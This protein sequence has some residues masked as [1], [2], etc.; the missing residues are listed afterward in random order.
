MAT[1]RQP[2]GP[3]RSPLAPGEGT[4]SVFACKVVEERDQAIE[5]RNTALSE[6]DRLQTEVAQLQHKVNFKEA[7]LRAHET[8]CKI[9]WNC[10]RIN[11]AAP[12]KVEP[13]KSPEGTDAARNLLSYS[14]DDLATLG[15]TLEQLS[16]LYKALASLV[17]N[18]ESLGDSWFSVMA[19]GPLDEIAQLEKEVAHLKERGK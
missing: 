8:N 10:P 1:K 13:S 6:V 4:W 18:K 16:H 9:G 12:L 11:E 15:V 3:N 19:E 14:G 17:D 7:Q 2:S 5:E